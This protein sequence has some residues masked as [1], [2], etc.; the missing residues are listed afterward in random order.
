MPARS[1]PVGARSLRA[2]EVIEAM[3][4][5]DASR[6]VVACYARCGE[7]TFLCGEEGRSAPAAGGMGGRRP[8]GAPPPP[9]GS[10]PH[11]D[12]RLCA[13]RHPRAHPHAELSLL[14]G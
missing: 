13:A 2:A 12:P 8:S 11:Q 10:H 14:L 7:A 4:A 3:V 9:P 6:I 1:V 5:Q